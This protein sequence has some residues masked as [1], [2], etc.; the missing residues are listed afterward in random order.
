MVRN[1]AAVLLGLLGLLSV[2]AGLFFSYR[3]LSLIFLGAFLMY[4]A[5]GGKRA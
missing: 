3:P 1:R 2:E 5:R 4:A